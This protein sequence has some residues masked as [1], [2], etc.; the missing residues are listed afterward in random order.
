MVHPYSSI[1]TTTAWKKLCFILL[2]SSDFYMLNKLSVVVHAFTWH[3]L[4]LLSADDKRYVKIWI[5]VKKSYLKIY[6]FLQM[7]IIMNFSKL[8]RI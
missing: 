6:S 2:D 5:I 3:I 1:D 4:M 8:I 7:I